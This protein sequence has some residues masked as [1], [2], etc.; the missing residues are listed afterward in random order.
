VTPDPVEPGTCRYCGC[1]QDN[2]CTIPGGDTCSWY[3]NERTV[4]T[5][6]ACIRQFHADWK[7]DEFRALNGLSKYLHGNPRP[8]SRRKKKV[9]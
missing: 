2:A 9:A 7:R 6:P 8:R 1:T 5:N 4:C 3:S